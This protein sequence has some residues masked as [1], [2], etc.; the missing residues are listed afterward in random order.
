MPSIWRSGLA[1]FG[2]PDTVAAKVV[3]LK[4]GPDQAY[5]WLILATG[6]AYSFFGHPEWSDDA[7]VLKSLDDALTIRRKLLAAFEKARAAQLKKGFQVM[8]VQGAA[9][10]KP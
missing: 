9:E 5:D 2:S 3:R 6:A 1:L 10:P 7:E 8:F 4:D